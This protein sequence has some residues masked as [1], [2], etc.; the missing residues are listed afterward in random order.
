MALREAIL[1]ALIHRDYLR[2]GRD[3]KIAIYD[4]LVEITSPGGFPNGITQDDISNG[5]SE[6]RNRVLANLF[7]ELGYIE[8]WG[9]GISRIRN[10]CK[11]KN[12]LFNIQ[13]KGDFVEV[14]F[15]RP[16]AT[17]SDRKRP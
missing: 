12:V 6:L 7:K 17:V 4:D 8:T 16:K 3:V 11:K 9:S 5:R 10:E 2:K 15:S 1:N 14:T 13:E